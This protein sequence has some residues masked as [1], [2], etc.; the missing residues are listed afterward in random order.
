[1]R[2]SPPP[3]DNPVLLDQ[4]YRGYSRSYRL[5]HTGQATDYLAY[6]DVLREAAIPVVQEAQGGDTR[7]VKASIACSGLFIRPVTLDGVEGAPPAHRDLLHALQIGA[8]DWRISELIEALRD[9]QRRQFVRVGRFEAPMGLVVGTEGAATQGYLPRSPD[10]Q[11]VAANRRVQ[12]QGREA[13]IE[14][15]EAG[16]DPDQLPG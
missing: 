3:A 8:P 14:V 4:A 9:D 2:V 15:R 1:M 13:C 11:H 10:R 16:Q 5:P 6:G 12:P 7:P